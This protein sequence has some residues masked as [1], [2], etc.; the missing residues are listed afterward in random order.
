MQEMRSSDTASS[1]APTDGKRMGSG[2]SIGWPPTPRCRSSASGRQALG[3]RNRSITSR[4]QWQEASPHLDARHAQPTQTATPANKVL[5]LTIGRGLH[6]AD[7]RSSAQVTEAVRVNLEVDAPSW[8]RA[9]QADAREACAV[10]HREAEDGEASRGRREVWL[11]AAERRRNL[12]W[13]SAQPAAEPMFA[14]G[15]A[16]IWR[17][18]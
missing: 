10:L 2:L 16:T 11:R 17:V 3:S 12:S 4:K 18:R 1:T 8:N 9:A 6:D 13:I 5:K 15:Y 7:L 14:T